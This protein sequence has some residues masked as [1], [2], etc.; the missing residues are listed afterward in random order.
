MT[1]GSAVRLASV[2]RHVTDS[3][4][5]PGTWNFV[6]SHYSSLHMWSTLAQ[7]LIMLEFRCMGHRFQPHQYNS[8]NGRHCDIGCPLLLSLEALCCVLEQ[9]T[10][11]SAIA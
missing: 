9:D 11:S 10:L 4:T 7:W 2:A 6:Y 3:A 8:I 1:P 5:R